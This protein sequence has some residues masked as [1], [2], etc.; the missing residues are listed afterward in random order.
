MR[1]DNSFRAFDVAMYR[2]DSPSRARASGMEEIAIRMRRQLEDDGIFRK[3]SKIYFITHSMGGLVV[4]RV[5]V[6]LNRPKEIEK[7]RRVKAVIYISTPA[8]GANIAELVS[9][10][11]VNPQFHD[12]RP[13]DLNSFLQGL[14]NQ[15]QD[16]VRDRGTQLF[17]RSFCAYETKPTNGVMVV[18][19]IYAATHCDQNPIPF[20][21]DH[22]SIVKPANADVDIYKWARA[23][24]Q[25]ASNPAQR[26]EYAEPAKEASTIVKVV[27]NCKQQL[28]PVSVRR[29][30]DLYAIMLWPGGGAGLAQFTWDPSATEIL[31]PSPDSI[32]KWVYRCELVNYGEVAVLALEVSLRSIFKEVIK[33]DEHTSTSGRIM[34]THD[35]PINIPLI[36]SV[37]GHVCVL[38]LQL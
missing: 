8:Q 10:W 28:L 18:S 35:H 19:R 3:Y 27:I 26:G 1:Q 38:R 9:L 16:L 36:D 34:T 5:L 21:E 30:S 12:M 2:Y 33:T 6:D 25:D 15:W 4:K 7:L 37:K 32:G 31:W 23:R 13:A 29:G 11:S 22:V 24:I 20:D 14:E 17:P